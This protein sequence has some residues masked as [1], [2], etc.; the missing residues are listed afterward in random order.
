MCVNAP[1]QSGPIMAQTYSTCKQW[2]G[3]PKYVKGYRWP[4]IFD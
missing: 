2:V 3:I 1:H 4:L